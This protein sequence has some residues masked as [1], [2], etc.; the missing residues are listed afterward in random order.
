[1]WFPEYIIVNNRKGQ[2]IEKARVWNG[3]YSLSWWNCTNQ[4]KS[5][6]IISND[7]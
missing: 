5:L 1:M 4:D 2:T 3:T 6:I 7:N